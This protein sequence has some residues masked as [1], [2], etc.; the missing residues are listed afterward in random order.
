MISAESNSCS[1]SYRIIFLNIE[2]MSENG[3]ML[4]FF[5][6]TFVTLYGEFHEKLPMPSGMTDKT[7]SSCTHWGPHASSVTNVDGTSCVTSTPL[8]FLQ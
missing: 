6:I 1:F 5:A 4:L 2:L 8:I 3:S 7:I